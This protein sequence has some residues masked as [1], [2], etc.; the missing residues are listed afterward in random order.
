[1][2]PRMMDTGGGRVNTIALTMA[3]F[4]TAA[5]RDRDRHLD[6][7]LGDILNYPHAD[8]PRIGRGGTT[9]QHLLEVGCGDANE[10]VIDLERFVYCPSLA[11]T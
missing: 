10:Q 6:V 9:M 11:C 3:A 5:P 1:M 4:T 2:I 8:L 7:T